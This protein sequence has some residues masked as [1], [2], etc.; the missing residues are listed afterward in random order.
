MLSIGL[1]MGTLYDVFEISRGVVNIIIKINRG[2][3][4]PTIQGV[5][6]CINHLLE[7]KDKLL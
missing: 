6:W 5:L 1:L 3:A 7:K 4:H 2:G